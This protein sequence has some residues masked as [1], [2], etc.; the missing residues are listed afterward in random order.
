[1]WATFKPIR[2][3]YMRPQTRLII[4]GISVAHCLKEV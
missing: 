3:H 1:M 2:K 4:G